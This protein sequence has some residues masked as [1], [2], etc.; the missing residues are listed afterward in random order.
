VNAGCTGVR[1]VSSRWAC[2]LIALAAVLASQF[3]ITA[4]AEDLPTLPN[5]VP[6]RPYDVGVGDPDDFAVDRVVRFSVSAMNHGRYSLEI[7]GEPQ[8]DDLD[9]S[10][11]A[12]QCVTWLVRVCQER[13]PVGHLI[14]HEQHRHWH[15]EGFARYELRRL[16]GD[17]RPDLSPDALVAGGQK[18]SFCLEDTNTAS[19]EGN[20]WIDGK[21]WLINASPLYKVCTLKRQ[22]IT[23]WWEDVYAAGLYGQQIDISN[24]PD[25]QY[26]LVVV[27][28][29][30]RRIL[31][32][33]YDDNSAFT[34]ITLLAGGTV[35]VSE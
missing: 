9:L 30:E 12:Y 26:A 2:A 25:G 3:T 23:S 16:G 7:Q 15:F 4:G 17:G 33:N 14:F 27:L 5:L 34:R 35:V 13:T 18:V 21:E 20:P 10:V 24:V 31:E 32:T 8:T 29:P 19:G 1:M 11:N 22:G 6:F 28:N